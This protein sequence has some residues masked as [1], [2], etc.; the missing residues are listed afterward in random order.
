[1]SSKKNKNQKK[2]ESV[3]IEINTP[4]TD[5]ENEQV[6]MTLEN[7]DNVI[8]ESIDNFEQEKKFTDS[9]T[10]SE[11]ETPVENESET[12]QLNLPDENAEEKIVI[13]NN[14]I[15]DINGEIFDISLH[16]TMPD[17]SPRKNRDGSFRKRKQSANNEQIEPAILPTLALAEYTVNS[18]EGI[19]VSMFGDEWY[20]QKNDKENE[21]ANII[22]AFAVYFASKGVVDL[23]PGVMLTLVLGTYAIRRIPQ[24][25]TKSKLQI[26]KDKIKSKLSFFTFRK[27]KSKQ[28]EQKEPQKVNPIADPYRVQ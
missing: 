28:S 11:Q 22:N 17:G 25:V 4:E 14:I 26:I 7:P 9:I 1:M 21:K 24:P 2:N 3:S 18:I 16:C 6:S 10:E 19:S 20:M 12:E 8:E 27:K 5:A 23:P 15:T 13:P